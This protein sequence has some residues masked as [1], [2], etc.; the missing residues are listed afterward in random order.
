LTLPSE[1]ALPDSNSYPAN[2]QKPFIACLNAALGRRLSSFV[3][4]L[5]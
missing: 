5:T 4:V 3:S 1:K 2:P